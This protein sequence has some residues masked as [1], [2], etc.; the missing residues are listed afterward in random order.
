MPVNLASSRTTETD[1]VGALGVLYREPVSHAIRFGNTA[2]AASG[3]RY[4]KG[5]FLL[6]FRVVAITVPSGTGELN[7]ESFNEL[8]ERDAYATRRSS[9]RPRTRA[10]GTQH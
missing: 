1:M 4:P 3:Y 9:S 8:R 7:D 10:Y 6:N 5:V 2:I